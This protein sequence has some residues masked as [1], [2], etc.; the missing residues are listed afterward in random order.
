MMKEKHGDHKNVYL[1][2]DLDVVMN[3]FYRQAYILVCSDK[4]CA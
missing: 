3:Y 2:V 1:A 4:V